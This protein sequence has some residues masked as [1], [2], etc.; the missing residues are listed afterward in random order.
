[1]PTNIAI[2]GAAG[3]MGQRLIVL[4]HADPEIHIV[5]ALESAS[6]PNLG[7]DVGVLCGIGGI[8]VLLSNQLNGAIDSVIDFSNPAGA[9][10][11]T[12]ECV[13]NGVPLVMATTGLDDEQ[14]TAIR[15]A[16]ETIP[17]VWAPNM[18]LAVNVTMKLVETT[19]RA[20]KDLESGVDVE[21]LERHHRYKEDAPSGT[22]L[23]FGQLV[24]EQMGQQIH[25]HGREGA[26]GKR[27]HE[28]IG[29]HAIRTGD[30][31]G[32]HTILFGLLGETIE[33]TV[34]A[35][36][37]DCYA[38]GAL[39]AAKWIAHKGPGLYTMYDVLGL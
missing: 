17:V 12:E 10:S 15:H 27:P 35:S 4:G 22:A 23:R 3:R 39:A 33:L 28:E 36:N 18:S 11:I 8:G 25:T 38:L 26:V 1:M 6:N 9:A 21:I 13:R 19:A 32:E 37:R 29:Y 31:P 14:Q 30:N 16:A 2:N 24:A 34:R 20:L 5:D 7:K